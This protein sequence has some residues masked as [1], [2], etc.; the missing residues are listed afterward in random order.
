[1]A[2]PDF[3][4]RVGENFSSIRS[5]AESEKNF[6][7]QIVFFLREAFIIFEGTNYK[8]NLKLYVK[9]KN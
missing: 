4:F 5:V 6:K 3:F 1:M 9:K 8:K 2:D 7:G